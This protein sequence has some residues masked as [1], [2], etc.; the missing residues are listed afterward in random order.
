MKGF[1]LTELLVTIAIIAIL[2]A[3]TVPSY[4][5]FIE[6]SKLVS[7]T[8]ELSSL[9][10]LM[11]QAYQADR[12]YLAGENCAIAEFSNEYFSQTCTGTKNTFTWTATSLAGVGLGFTADY[13]Y[14]INQDGTKTT[15]RF[16]GSIPEHTAGWIINKKD[17]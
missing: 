3:L 1:T 14:T 15:T 16:A 8:E 6:R 7:G 17:L 13:I 9:R 5:T 10:G 12:T 2:A 4:V 11:E